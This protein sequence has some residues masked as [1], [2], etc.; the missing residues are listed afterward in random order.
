MSTT[1]NTKLM[2]INTV[3]P[4][5]NQFT[6]IISSIALVPKKLYY[7]GTLPDERIPTV[8]IVGTR[9][10]TTY[11]IEVTERLSYD[12]AKRGVAIISGLAL[13]VDAIA[14]RA[15]LKAGGTTFA[16][17]ANGLENIYPATNRQLADDIVSSGGAILSEYEPTF[18]ARLYTFLERNRIVSGLS[19]AILIT[20]ASARSG[21]LNTARHALEQ[22]KDVFV[23]PG[24]ITSPSSAGCNNLIKQGA[25]VVTCA[26]DILEVIAPQLLKSQVT[27]ALGDNT[28][29]SEIIALLQAGVRDGEVLQ[30]KAQISAAEFASEITMME[31]NGTIRSL[32][33]NQW[34]LK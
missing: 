2:K 32:G 14:H 6:Q 10:P 3:I 34:T 11:G 13:G 22:G 18:R 21:T 24:N 28:V 23:V 5:D 4:R 15:A 27:L 17:Q 33:A 31:L 7:I 29:Q 9:K 19:D 20:E 1:F 26:E 8:A 25:S 30:N 12:L 16:V